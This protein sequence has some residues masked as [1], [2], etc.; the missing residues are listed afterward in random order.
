MPWRRRRRERAV[1]AEGRVLKGERS[2]ARLQAFDFVHDVAWDRFCT[3]LAP[4][5]PQ[6][7]SPATILRATQVSVASMPE[8][9]LRACQ[10]TS[11]A[12]TEL[13]RRGG[14]GES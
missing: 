14:R 10:N 6:Q 3:Q 7:T 9:C 4:F 11:R 1:G 13:V 2:E 12:R 8:N 5:S